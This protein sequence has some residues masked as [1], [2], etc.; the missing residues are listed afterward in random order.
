MTRARQAYVSYRSTQYT[1][2]CS[3]LIT[4]SLVKLG[5]FDGPAFG[6]L[7][8]LSLIFIIEC[9]IDWSVLSFVIHSF[10]ERNTLILVVSSSHTK[11]HHIQQV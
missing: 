5:L 2:T 1:G 4:G 9:L 7:L 6:N 3:G 10:V 8:S 11:I